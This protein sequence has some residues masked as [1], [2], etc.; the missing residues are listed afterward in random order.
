MASRKAKN[1]ES[2][3]KGGTTR[4]GIQGSAQ[5]GALGNEERPSVPTNPETPGVPEITVEGGERRPNEHRDHR[6]VGR[7]IPPGRWGASGGRGAAGEGGSARS[8]PPIAA[9]PGHG[10][11]D[12]GLGQAA[13]TALFA[14][15][16]AQDCRGGRAVS[17]QG[18]GGSSLA[19]GRLVLLASGHL[20]PRSAGGP[21]G[22]QAR[23]QA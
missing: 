5:R 11:R 23:A 18:R 13:P 3:A 2:L 20:A 10:R 17:G 4:G 1:A 21:A 12:G 6:E 22:A 8:W 16:Q 9:A 14:R 15:V 19:P 7:Q